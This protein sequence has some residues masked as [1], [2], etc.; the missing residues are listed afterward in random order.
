MYL[1]GETAGAAYVSVGGAV[2]S[3]AVD[4]PVRDFE[5]AMQQRLDETTAVLF[6]ADELRSHTVEA[7]FTFLTPEDRTALVAAA[8]SREYAADEVVLEEGARRH[9]LFIV[10]Q[11]A[12]RVSP[13][14]SAASDRGLLEEGELFGDMSFLENAAASA[15]VIADVP[16]R[17]DVIEREAIYAL[18]AEPPG[19]RRPVLPVARHAAVRPAAPTSALLDAALAMTSGPEVRP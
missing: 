13:R 9:G 5:E 2:H 10:R 8:G 4:D 17:I 1:R 11:G 7:A 16:C 18:L 6:G 14:S 19:L 3:D 15:D 12:V